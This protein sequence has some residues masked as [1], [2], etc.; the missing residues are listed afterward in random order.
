MNDLV[1]AETPILIQQIESYLAGEIDHIAMREFAWGFTERSP[2]K[3]PPDEESFWSCIFT[4]IHLADADHWR[5]GCTQRD[6]T[7][8]LKLLRERKPI[9]DEWR[10]Q[11]SERDGGEKPTTR[12]ESK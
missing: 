12:S 11:K 9:T 6:L 4:I 1:A 3:P 10:I 5:D 2:E 8:F 7:Q